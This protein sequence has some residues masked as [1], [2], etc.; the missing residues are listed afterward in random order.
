[1]TYIEVCIGMDRKD[2]NITDFFQALVYEQE[3][4]VTEDEVCKAL[5]VEFLQASRDD[6]V[7][8]LTILC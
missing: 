7:K 5:P 4:A 6:G 2:I 1:M 8:V 3:L